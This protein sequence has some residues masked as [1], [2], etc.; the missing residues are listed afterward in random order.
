MAFFVQS[1]FPETGQGFYLR[2]YLELLTKRLGV[3]FDGTILRGGMEGTHVQTEKQNEKVYEQMRQIGKTYAETGI[4]DR[5]VKK[6]YDKMAYLPKAVI[7]IYSILA[8]TGMMDSY[9]HD[10]LKKNGT[11]EQRR[12]R[13]YMK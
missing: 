10:A 6:E 13:P 7:A 11:Y 12:A 5:A 4:M 3:T 1:G 8:A 2:P 9:W